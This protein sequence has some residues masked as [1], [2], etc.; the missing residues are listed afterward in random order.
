LPAR[1]SSIASSIGAK[2]RVWVPMTLIVAP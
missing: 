2:T 1:M